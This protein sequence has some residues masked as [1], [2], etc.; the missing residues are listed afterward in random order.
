MK[1]LKAGIKQYML[2]IDIHA[3]HKCLRKRH[4]KLITTVASGGEEAGRIG[5]GQRWPK[6]SSEVFVQHSLGVYKKA[7]RAKWEQLFNLI[8]WKVGV[9]SPERQRQEE[10][11]A[12]RDE[13]TLQITCNAACNASSRLSAWQHVDS[14]PVLLSCLPCLTLAWNHPAQWPHCVPPPFTVWNPSNLN[15]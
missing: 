5:I 11:E 2:P 15:L 14:D 4:I 9:C 7:N 3:I 13:I 1:L 8:R 6:G 10:T 12:P